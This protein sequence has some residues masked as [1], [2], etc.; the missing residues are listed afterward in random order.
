MLQLLW[1]RRNSDRRCGRALQAT[2]VRKTTK[3]GGRVRSGRGGHL[4]GLDGRILLWERLRQVLTVGL[5][6]SAASLRLRFRAGRECEGNQY[7]VSDETHSGRPRG[8]EGSQSA[9]IR[10]GFLELVSHGRILLSGT[11][12]ATPAVCEQGAL[13]QRS[14][15]AGY[16]VR[17]RR[18]R[19]V[20][21]ENSHART[22]S[23]ALQP[24][25]LASDKRAS[26]R[27]ST[28]NSAARRSRDALN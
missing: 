3:K 28:S 7:C 16:D 17:A 6:R 26:L 20:N 24:S 8:R 21:S 12:E 1:R 4:F 22:A 10:A 25:R 2:R 27:A 18:R 14:G 13:E 9:D 19:R 15:V 11:T 23:T 5:R